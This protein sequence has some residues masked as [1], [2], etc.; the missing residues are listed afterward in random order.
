MF[1][2]W[3]LGRKPVFE[4]Y[5]C[6]ITSLLAP[7]SRQPANPSSSISRL[8]RPR[9]MGTGT[10]LMSYTGTGRQ[11]SHCH[12]VLVRHPRCRDKIAVKPLR[13]LL[14][15]ADNREL[16]VPLEGARYWGPCQSLIGPTAPIYHEIVLQIINCRSAAWL[17]LWALLRKRKIL[18]KCLVF[19]TFRFNCLGL[20]H[21]R[22]A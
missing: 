3:F 17:H 10:M 12:D 2:E 5:Y 20:A 8:R 21:D 16:R 14:S 1:H 9:A 4:R 7:L 6:H 18:P 22:L 19:L 11:D 13:P 15:T